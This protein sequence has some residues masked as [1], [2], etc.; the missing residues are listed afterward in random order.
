MN[1]DKDV[2]SL[3]EAYQQILEKDVTRTGPKTVNRQDISNFIYIK[4]SIILNIK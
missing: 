1:I 2:I 4:S 3:Q